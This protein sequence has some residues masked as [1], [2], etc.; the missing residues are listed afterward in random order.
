MNRALSLPR[1]AVVARKFQIGDDAD[2]ESTH[3]AASANGHF[4]FQVNPV[5][6]EQLLNNKRPR[7]Q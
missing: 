1:L 3:A 5:C 7:R 4:L 6:G 2:P